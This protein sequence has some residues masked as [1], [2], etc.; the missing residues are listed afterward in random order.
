MPAMLNNVFSVSFIA[1]ID[2]SRLFLHSHQD[3]L[4]LAATCP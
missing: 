2:G 1:Q 4:A 3:L